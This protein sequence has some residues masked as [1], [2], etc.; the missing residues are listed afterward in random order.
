ML[1][2]R[3]RG[4]DDHRFCATS[5][6]TQQLPHPSSGTS[7]HVCHRRATVRKC[8]L[9]SR[10]RDSAPCPRCATIVF[11]TCSSCR[12]GVAGVRPRPSLRVHAPVR[13]PCPVRR[14]CQG[15]APALV[16]PMPQNR[17]QDALELA[18][19]G[20]GPG[21][22]CAKPGRLQLPRRPGTL[23]GSAPGRVARTCGVRS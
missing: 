2:A 16:A 19:P 7:G 21:P 20:L 17:E 9:G 4:A 1:Q 6:R 8:L 23:Q 3:S 14:R 10:S 11:L 5:S 12:V 13:E 15:S 22:R 18:L